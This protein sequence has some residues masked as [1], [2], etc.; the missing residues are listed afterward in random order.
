MKLKHDILSKID[1]CASTGK[2][3]KDD[4]IITCEAQQKLYPLVLEAIQLL[5]SLN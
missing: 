2:P 1:G 3:D 4:W 5:Q